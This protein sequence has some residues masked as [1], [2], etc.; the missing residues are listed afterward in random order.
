MYFLL[1]ICE[2]IWTVFSYLY[3]TVITSFWSFFLNT[4]DA[5]GEFKIKKKRQ[6]ALANTWFTPSHRDHTWPF[7]VVSLYTQ[8]S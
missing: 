8:N 3:N 1:L 4:V 6:L 2:N 7:W 5:R